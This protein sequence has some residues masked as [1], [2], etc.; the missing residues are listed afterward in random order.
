MSTTKQVDLQALELKIVATCSQWHADYRASIC[1]FIGKAPVQL[2]DLTAS[3]AK[4]WKLWIS[5]E[6]GE[7]SLDITLSFIPVS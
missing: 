2:T 6:A 5:I 7:I 3:V 1:L 4:N